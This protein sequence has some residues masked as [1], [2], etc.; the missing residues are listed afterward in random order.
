MNAITKSN[1]YINCSQS[2]LLV[3]KPGVRPFS[4]N[5]STKSVCT[6]LS[7]YLYLYKLTHVS[8]F[9]SGK[10]SLYARDKGPI[11]PTISYHTSKLQF[12]GGFLFQAKKRVWQLITGIESGFHSGLFWCSLTEK[13][14][15]RP[16][17]LTGNAYLVVWKVGVT[18]TYMNNKFMLCYL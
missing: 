1:D 11:N 14:W 13:Q 5:C 9:L 3:F 18:R 8:H 7:T 17:R 6:Y 10:Y 16:I 4:W 12:K 15:S 2:P